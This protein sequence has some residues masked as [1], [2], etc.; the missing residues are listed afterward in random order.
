M[1][2]LPFQYFQLLSLLLA[3]L[4]SKGLL[5]YGIILFIPLLIIINITEILGVNYKALGWKDNYLLYN[6]N[7]LI[8]STVLT[9]FLYYKMLEMNARVRQ[10]FL[11]VAILLIIFLLLNICFMQGPHSFNTYSLIVIEL[12]NIILSCI[13]LFQLVFSTSTSKNLFTE[14]YFWINTGTLFFTLGT[15][16]LFG[17]QQYILKNEIKLNDKSLYYALAPILNIFLYSAWGYGFLLCRTN[18]S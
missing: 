13:V 3:I 12:T 9:L 11:M 1:T 14:P 4:C 18:K 15:I 7:Y 10:V 16:V 17:L 5:K 6:I 2:V 8:I